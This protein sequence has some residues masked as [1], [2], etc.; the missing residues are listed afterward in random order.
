MILLICMG[1][2]IQ[3]AEKLPVE[4]FLHDVRHQ[5]RS[6]EQQT[7]D[8]S[9]P[10]L[11]RRVHVEMHVIA[12]KDQQGKTAY[13]VLQGIQDRRNV[14]TQKLS[15]DIELRHPVPA[16]DNDKRYRSYSTRRK[17]YVYGPDSYRPS[18]QYPYRPDYYMPDIY[19]VILYNNEQ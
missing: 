6:I 7:D 18:R 1:T 10:A 9:M 12:E 15:F 11:V 14:I 5:L 13:Y 19:P 17:E 16:A 8:R 4:E 3:A 2:R